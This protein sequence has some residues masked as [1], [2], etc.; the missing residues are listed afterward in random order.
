MKHV[1][2]KF[3][4]RIWALRHLR[5]NGF[6]TSE[7]LTVY[8]TMVRPVAEYCSTVYHALITESDSHELER[9]QMQA[10]KSIYSWKLSYSTLPEKSGLERLS[11]RREAAFN[12]LAVKMSESARFSTWFPLRLYR[13]EVNIRNKEKYKIYRASTGRCLKSP[14]NLNLILNLN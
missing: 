3:K 4:N 6:K 10:L 1:Q 11:T 7:L 12:K 14:L 2:K 8:K 13:N 5:K 9:I